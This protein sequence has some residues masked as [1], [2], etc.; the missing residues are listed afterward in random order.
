VVNAQV[1]FQVGH[2][3]DSV[4]VW[5]ACYF[6][7]AHEGKNTKRAQAETCTPFT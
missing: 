4:K 2:R 7:G 1:A 6:D 5:C 3:D